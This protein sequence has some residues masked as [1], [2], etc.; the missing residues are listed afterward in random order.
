[1]DVEAKAKDGDTP[2]HRAAHGG[3]QEIVK[4]LLDKGANLEVRTH[5]AYSPLH[6]AD[7]DTPLHHAGKHFALSF[8]I[9]NKLL[10]D[11]AEVN[12]KTNYGFT[13]L[14]RSVGPQW[15]LQAGRGG[16]AKAWMMAVVQLL[17][18]NGAY[19]HAA[20][21]LGQ[22][23]YHLASALG[24]AEVAALLHAVARRAECQTFANASH[25]D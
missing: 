19:V 16:E 8:A 4:L 10:D 23:A 24:H 15:G 1:A 22:T 12:A 3:H 7:S 18:V 11:G 17:L 13:P 20:T 6:P 14:H 9:V 5:A 2:L 21:R 25:S